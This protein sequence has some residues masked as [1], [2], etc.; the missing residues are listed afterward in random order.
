MVFLCVP[1]CVLNGGLI[2]VNQCH[3]CMPELNELMTHDIIV[4]CK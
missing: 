1:V 4:V 2:E 3:A